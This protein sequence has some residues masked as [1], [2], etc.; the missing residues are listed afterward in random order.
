MAGEAAFLLERALL[1]A[2][3]VLLMAGAA[4]VLM[5]ANAAK[6]LGGFVIASFGAL[7][8]LAALGSPGGL[9]VAVAAAAFAQLA[10]GVALLVRLQEAYGAIE[11]PEIDAADKQSEPPERTP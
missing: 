11:T 1:A 9:L 3:I 10:V 5:A 8:A 4:T 7:I 6:R 2:A